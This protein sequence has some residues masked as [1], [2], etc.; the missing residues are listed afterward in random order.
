MFRTDG[1]I[2]DNGTN[3]GGEEKVS[4]ARSTHRHRRRA[5][6]NEISG[7]VYVLSSLMEANQKLVT[8]KNFGE[9]RSPVCRSVEFLRKE[10]TQ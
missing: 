8:K 2:A 6:L 9:T 4:L 5:S 3:R 10:G 7:Y 1:L